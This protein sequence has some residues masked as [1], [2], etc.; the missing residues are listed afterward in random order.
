VRC[1]FFEVEERVGIAPPVAGLP[2][3]P[4]TLAVPGFEN[5]EQG[6]VVQ[7]R[8]IVFRQELVIDLVQFRSV[9]LCETP[10]R[11]PEQ[12][13]LDGDQGTVVDVALGESPE[14][15]DLIVG[16]EAFVDEIADVD[17]QLVAGKRR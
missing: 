5:P 7:P 10:G 9:R 11:H 15:A 17:Q 4:R 6:I 3:R 12:S 2:L 8:L 16:Q 1:G 14:F 13:G